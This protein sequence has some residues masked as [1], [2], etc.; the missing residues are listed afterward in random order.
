MAHN[1]EMER[2]VSK[3]ENPIKANLLRDIS[4]ELLNLLRIKLLIRSKRLLSQTN[5]L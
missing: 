2:N 3:K 1:P 4:I 5:L